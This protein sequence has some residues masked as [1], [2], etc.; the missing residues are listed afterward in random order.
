M[1]PN[2]KK[3]TSQA[4]EHKL[5]I[6]LEKMRAEGEFRR[7]HREAEKLYEQFKLEVWSLGE[8]YPSAPVKVG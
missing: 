6:R 2:K 5:A 7:T 8:R 3:H 4:E 1:R